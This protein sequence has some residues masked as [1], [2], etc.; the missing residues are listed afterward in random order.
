MNKRI[1]A[2]GRPYW[3]LNDESQKML[4]GGYLLKGETVEMA[5]ER[6]AGSASARL[7]KPELKQAFT[8][9]IENGWMSLS[10]PVWANSGTNRGLPISC[11]N[12][13]VADDMASIGTKLSEV[14]IQTKH[15]G[16]TSGSF[17]ALRGRGTEVTNNG[18]ATGAVSFMKLFDTAMDTVSQ[19]DVR[20][21]AFASYLNI[22]HLDISEF[23]DIRSVG[24]P[25]QNLYTGVTVPD[26]WMEDMVAG[27][28]GK[29]DIWAKVLKSR[30]ETGMPYIM[31]SDTVNNNKPYIYKYLDISIDSSNLCSEIMLPSNKNESFV[32][33]LSSMNIGL[34]D[35]WKDTDAV[36][37]AIFFLDSIISEFIDKTK[38]LAYMDSARNFAIRHRAVGLGVLGWHSYLQENMI[39]F[40]SLEANMLSSSIFRQLKNQSMSASIELGE[41]LGYAPIFDENESFDGVKMRNTTQMAIAPTTSSS[42]ILGQVSAGIEPFSSNLFKVG[43]AKGNFIRKN[44]KLEAILEEK[45]MNTDEVW[46]DIMMKGGS[47]QHIEWLSDLEKEV[48]LTFP[49]I[50]QMDIITQASIRQKFIDQSQSLNINIP[51]GVS[52]KDTNSLIIEAW[53][54]G[55]KTIYYQRSSSV[56]KDFVKSVVS[57]SSC[58]S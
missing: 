20:K 58:E 41:L 16:G 31:F 25:I 29:R 30:K 8:E 57:C 42:A 48:F 18:K 39:P 27:D 26:Y 12:V 17:N 13:H 44:I 19:G 40:G 47:V 50:S 53:K 33:C 45:G 55:V 34:Y 35:E 37:Y 3:W 52:V 2:T 22:D 10:S 14:I 56:S 24:N 23:L 54:L 5:V 32:C 21:G 15:G 49:E 6:I 28:K 46:N 11:F 51:N 7:G 4:N 38:G 1:F 9:I 36:R 43:L